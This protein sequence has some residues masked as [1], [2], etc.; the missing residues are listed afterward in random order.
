MF[1]FLCNCILI[2]FACGE[3]FC[4]LLY[5]SQLQESIF[6]TLCRIQNFNQGNKV[7]QMYDS[8]SYMCFLHTVGEKDQFM[9]S[10]R[11]LRILMPPA[12][13]SKLLIELCGAENCLKI[14]K[15]QCRKLHSQ[16]PFM[17]IQQHAFQSVPPDWRSSH[18]SFGQLDYHPNM[19][20]GYVLVTSLCLS[21]YSMNCSRQELLDHG[22]CITD[23]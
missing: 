23:R 5:L 7:A 12:K 3:N 20:I 21:V 2:I 22:I 9:Y 13:L 19:W 4:S 11:N 17:K 1:N 16:F 8:M 10:Y 18:L 14:E 6:L 15:H